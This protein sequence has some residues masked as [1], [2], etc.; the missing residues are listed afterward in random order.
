MGTRRILDI[1]QL[2]ETKHVFTIKKTN[3][4]SSMTKVRRI[5]VTRRFIGNKEAYTEGPQE[6]DTTLAYEFIN[7]VVKYPKT[8][9]QTR[10]RLNKCITVS[11]YIKKRTTATPYG[12]NK[13]LSCPWNAQYPLQ[14]AT[15]NCNFNINLMSLFSISFIICCHNYYKSL[16]LQKMTRKMTHFD[17][18]S[19]FRLSFQFQI[20]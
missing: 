8:Q 11:S 16:R 5:T 10:E 3:S 17:D 12:F 15:I 19:T 1:N 2:R 18:R 7:R 14:V 20:N 4:Q 9:L 6:K 13:Y